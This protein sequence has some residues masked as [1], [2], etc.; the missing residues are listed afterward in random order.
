FA[1]QAAKIEET[2]GAGREKIEGGAGVD[3]FENSR[4]GPAHDP[5]GG[6]EEEGAAVVVARNGN[7]RVADVLRRYCRRHWCDQAAAE[8]SSIAV[9]LPIRV[10]HATLLRRERKPARDGRVPA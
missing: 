6:A 2:H 1:R 4:E 10:P 9:A 3:E 8:E 5:T 7:R